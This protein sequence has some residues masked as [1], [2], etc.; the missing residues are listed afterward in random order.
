M[1]SKKE[2]HKLPPHRSYDHHIP[3]QEGAIPPF[4]SIYTL[5]PE[6]LKALREYV[7]N[8]LKKQFIRHSQSSCSSPILFTRKADG[9]LRLCVDYRGLNKL[10]IKNRY[11]LPLIGQILEQVSQARYFTDF[12]LRDGFYLLRMGKGE[13]WKTAFRCRSELFEYQVMSFGLCNAPG[14]FQHFTNDT[15]SDFLDDF[16]AIYLDDLLIYSKT[17]KEHKRHVR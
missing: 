11:L 5:T 9:I 15:F 14:T 10:T 7:D 8:N 2:A 3:L 17:L 4:G 6:E 12:D 16:L 13:E 1:F